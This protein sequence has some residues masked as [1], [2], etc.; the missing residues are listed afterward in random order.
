[1]LGVGHV[2]EYYDSDKLFPVY[3]FGGKV[4]VGGT[5]SH[6]FAVNMNEAGPEVQGVKGILDSYYA[7]L[8]QVKLSGPTIFQNVIS[9]AAAFAASTVSSDP[10]RQKYH[11][12]LILTDGI[13][14]DMQNTI[15]A[16]VQASTLPF[17]IVIV[18]VGNADFTAMEVLDAD[19]KRLI[20]SS[21]TQAA[22]DIV[23]FVP[24]NKFAHTSPEVIAREVLYE[25]PRQFLDYMQA[26][27]ISP[28]PAR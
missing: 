10:S 17:S 18:G 3:G 11:I 5:A 23:Q 9:S 21:G 28:M 26:N 2:L 8:Q 14:N 6:C 20:S 4:T 16:I 12:L 13:I 25:I 7:S 1:M 22:R 27:S 19:D 15:D 24:M